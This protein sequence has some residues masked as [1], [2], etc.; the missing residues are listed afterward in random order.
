MSTFNNLYDSLSYNISTDDLTFEEK[1]EMVEIMKSLK[2]KVGKDEM[3]STKFHEMNNIIFELITLDY[4]KYNPHTK[5]V[6]PYKT[7][8]IDDDK[9]EIKLDC[10][11]IRLK[12]ILY[13][14]ITVAKKNNIEKVNK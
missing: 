11:P 3:D 13:R 14:F 4:N 7:K 1:D 12:Q 8:Q 10:L 6:Y 5:V 9:I 2:D